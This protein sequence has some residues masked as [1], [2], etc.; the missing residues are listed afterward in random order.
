DQVQC[1][2]FGCGDGGIAQCCPGGGVC[3]HSLCPICQCPNCNGLDPVAAI[4]YWN[5][6]IGP[7]GWRYKHWNELY[8][9]KL[10][11]LAS[12]HTPA[13]YSAQRAG[14]GA[15]SVFG[16]ALSA[17]ACASALVLATAVALRRARA[18]RPDVGQGFGDGIGEA[19][20]G[21]ETEMSAAARSAGGESEAA[22]TYTPF[23][24]ADGP[25]REQR[26]DAYAP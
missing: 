8:G 15:F 12:A 10:P 7:S 17:L 6:T 21:G 14:Y 24:A 25:R 3:P 2:P 18:L 20:L 13:G 11:L 19:L 1:D 22:Y 16:S 4:A 9:P 5:A 23:L 26:R